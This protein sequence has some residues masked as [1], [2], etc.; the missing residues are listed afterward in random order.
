MNVQHDCIS[1]S[2]DTSASRPVQQERHI[3][4]HT[5]A[6]VAHRGNPNAL[7]LNTAQMRDA[8]HL[9]PYCVPRPVLDV[10]EVE[11]VVMESS[12]AEI[13]KRKQKVAELTTPAKVASKKGSSTRPR[14]SLL[15]PRQ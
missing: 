1:S 3:T 12:V 9:Q 6:R 7:I 2:C 5:T 4:S 14:N 10:S 15:N 8:V 11:R 13:T